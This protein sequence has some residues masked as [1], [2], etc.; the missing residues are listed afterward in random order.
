MGLRM[1]AESPINNHGTDAISLSASERERVKQHIRGIVRQISAET[2]EEI[3]LSSEAMLSKAHG[4]TGE[5][6]EIVQSDPDGSHPTQEAPND[7]AH[8]DKCALRK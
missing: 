3:L 2:S 4:T 1:S 6:P 7:A 8:I 5:A